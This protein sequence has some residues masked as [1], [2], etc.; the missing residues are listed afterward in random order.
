MI[1][2][3]NTKMKVRSLNERDKPTTKYGETVA[4]ADDV[5]TYVGNGI[6]SVDRY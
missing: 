6:W 5:V 2:E 4:Y 1:I 3:S